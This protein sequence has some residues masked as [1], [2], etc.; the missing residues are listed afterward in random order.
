MN[1]VNALVYYDC[2]IANVV[3][4]TYLFKQYDNPY[5]LHLNIQCSR[6]PASLLVA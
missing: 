1:L 2:S 4:R 5:K 6:T 3:N